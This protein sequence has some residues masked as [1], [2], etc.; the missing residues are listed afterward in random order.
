[1]SGPTG[2][3]LAT[4]MTSGG[5]ISPQQQAL[6]QYTMGEQSVQGASEFAGSGMPVSTGETWAGGVAPMV[7]GAYTAARTSD[8]DAAAQQSALS[9]KFSQAGSN[10]GQLGSLA[11]GKA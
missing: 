9:S 8:A 7:T 3:K 4:N 2:N 11:G 1:M 5:G 10:V 6:A